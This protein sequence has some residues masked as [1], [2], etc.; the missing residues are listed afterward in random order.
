MSE[1]EGH[2]Q[3]D[4]DEDADDDGDL[5]SNIEC[6]WPQGS[7]CVS[8][9]QMRCIAMIKHLMT[10]AANNESSFE[11]HDMCT[12]LHV[13]TKSDSVWACVRIIYRGLMHLQGVSDCAIQPKLVHQQFPHRQIPPKLQYTCYWR[14]PVDSDIILTVQQ[15]CHG[16]AGGLDWAGEGQEGG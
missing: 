4:V 15:V 10:K 6:P 3:A 1:D 7:R 2:S 9:L 13:N 12:E 14:L 11:V 8:T 16:L 5:V